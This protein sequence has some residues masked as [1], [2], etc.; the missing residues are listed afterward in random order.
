MAADPLATD[1]VTLALALFLDHLASAAMP[2]AWTFVCAALVIGWLATKGI[3]R[4]PI[5]LRMLDAIRSIVSAVAIAAALTIA[6]RA[7]FT[8]AS[9]VAEETIEPSS[10]HGVR[11]RGQS[12]AYLFRA[13]RQEKG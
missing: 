7:L 5:D 13:P 4:P 1:V 10:L 8:D 9:A 6:L 3:Y 12:L 2:V 11:P